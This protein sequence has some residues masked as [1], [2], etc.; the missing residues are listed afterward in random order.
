[1]PYDTKVKETSVN[2]VCNHGYY[3][4]NNVV[5]L[6]GLD[7]AVKFT[8]SQPFVN[9]L[10]RYAVWFNNQE[11][12]SESKCHYW[13]HVEAGNVS[14]TPF[15]AKCEQGFATISIYGGKAG[16]IEFNQL[17]LDT[18]SIP[19]A[20]CQAGV[21]IQD[22]NP[23]KRCYWE[24]KIDCSSNSDRQLRAKEEEQEVNGA[25]S[26]EEESKVVD[27]LDVQLDKTCPVPNTSPV[28][29]VSQDRD[30]VI[31]T[32]SQVWKGCGDNESGYTLDW[33]ATDFDNEQGKLTCVGKNDVPCGSFTT[34]KSECTDGV[35]FIDLFASDADAIKRPGTV[36]VPPACSAP[37]EGLSTCHYRYLVQ[38]KPSLCNENASL[39]KTSK[40]KF[41]RAWLDFSI[42]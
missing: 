8:L 30:F 2:T 27:V 26:C 19:Q 3:G 13:D 34:L 36:I 24:F 10:D 41:L 9:G 23:N 4:G 7:D 14:R 15:E 6:E 12:E 1:V 35:A 31:F 22:Y 20:R 28:S 38:C 39:P 17:G 25:S 37:P 21:D 16:G 29:I 40:Q 32:I 5:R 11:N 18:S 42:R 33:L